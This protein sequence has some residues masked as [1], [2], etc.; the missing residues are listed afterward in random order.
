LRLSTAALDYTQAFRREVEEDVA[1]A[2]A[3]PGLNPLRR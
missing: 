3:L 2:D 1:K